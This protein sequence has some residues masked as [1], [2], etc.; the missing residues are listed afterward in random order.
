MTPSTNRDE[1]S[2]RCFP[3]NKRGRSCPAP[4][5]I[6]R[7]KL[8]AYVERVV[9]REIDRLTISA[10]DRSDTLDRASHALRAAEAELEAFQRAV[11]VAE[12]GEGAFVTGLRSRS[13]AVDEARRAVAES[14]TRAVVLPQPGTLG[15]QWPGLSV[16]ERGHVLR[17]ALAA[18]FVTK[19]SGPAEDRVRLIDGAFPI[20]AT[21][22]GDLEGEIGVPS[23]QDLE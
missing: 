17:S 2:Y 22:V 12:V 18:V 5:S 15:S 13:Q 6:S 10:T 11:Q 8:D 3:H 19:G 7:G 23:V 21:G 20:P 1:R 14:R 4:A 9:L 16:T